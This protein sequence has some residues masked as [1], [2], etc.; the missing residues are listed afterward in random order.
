MKAIVDPSLSISWAQFSSFFWILD[1]RKLETSSSLCKNASRSR[2]RHI[3]GAAIAA[4]L[5]FLASPMRAQCNQP[6]IPNPGQTVTW[7][8]AN[9]P[10]Q[11]CSELTIPKNGTVIVQPGVVLQFQGHT[12]TVS[13][14]IKLQG[15]AASPITI[16]ATS[17]FPPAITLAGGNVNMQFANITGQLRGGP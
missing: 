3:L 11:I 13:G 1:S 12:L 10:F 7:M 8:T 17:N 14:T 16:S 6:P 15:Q 2:F 5:F 9:S 4:S